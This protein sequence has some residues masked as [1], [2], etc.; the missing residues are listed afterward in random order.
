[1]SHHTSHQIRVINHWTVASLQREARQ[2]SPI[3]AVQAC[4]GYLVI[5]VLTAEIKTFVQIL[6]SV[7]YEISTSRTTCYNIQTRHIRMPHPQ[8]VNKDSDTS[9]AF[10][11]T[12]L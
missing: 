1:M 9:G 7:P 2:F 4:A 11:V 12:Y 6:N 10:L 5:S 8:S 3:S